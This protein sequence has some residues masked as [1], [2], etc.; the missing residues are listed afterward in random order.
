M[1]VRTGS[2]RMWPCPTND[3]EM[4]EY[5]DGDIMDGSGR[6]S[7]PIGM[8]RGRSRGY[9]NTAVK[10]ETARRSGHNGA[11]DRGR[12]PLASRL[13]SSPSACLIPVSQESLIMKT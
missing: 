12:P 4:T 1:H 7:S 10:N 9:E 5:Q 11:S 2:L 6:R 3:F 8:S 13:L